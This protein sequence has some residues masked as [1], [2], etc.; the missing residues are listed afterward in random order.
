LVP[1]PSDVGVDDPVDPDVFGLVVVVVDFSVV[2]V[3]CL[4]VGV[5]LPHSGITRRKPE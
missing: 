4:V 1:G 2:G 3:V 5:V